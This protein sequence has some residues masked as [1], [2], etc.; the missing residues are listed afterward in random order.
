MARHVALVAG[1]LALLLARPLA[2]QPARID[3]R[4]PRD[5]PAKNASGAIRG[6]VTGADNGQPLRKAQVRL[7][8][9]GEGRMPTRFENQVTTTDAQGR[10][11]FAELPAGRYQLQAM[12]GGYVSLEYG[13]RRPV[14]APKPIELFAAQT[15]EKIDFA[16]PRG[17]VIAGRVFDEFGEPSA[18]VSVAAMR[19]QYDGRGR[20]RLMSASGA[21]TNDLGEFR[22]FALPPGDY[23]LLVHVGEF[24]D[25]IDRGTYAPLYYPGTTDVNLAER[26]TVASGQTIANLTL[27]LQTARTARVSGTAT[28]AEGKPMPG[29]MVVNPLGAKVAGMNV[30]TTIVQPDGSFTVGGLTPG[31]YRFVA[32]GVP[33]L[34][35]SE[36]VT[37]SATVAV[38][39]SD[40]AGL[41]VVAGKPVMAAGKI[42]VSG[43]PRAS[44]QVRHSTLRLLAASDD[45]SMDFSFNGNND[46][47][48][49]NDDGSFQIAL[50]PGRMRLLVIG[51]P[52]EWSMK[53]VR[54]GGVD[55]TDTGIDVKPAED[56][57]SLEIEL[58]D[59]INQTIG[60]VVNERNEPVKDYLVVI[61]SKDRQ[62]WSPQ[63]R[64]VRSVRSDQ[65]GRFTVGGLPS[66]EY[67][68]YATDF[69]EPGQEHDVEFLDRIQPLATRFLL[70]D[71]ETHTVNL[72]LHPAP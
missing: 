10:F 52:P 4:S 15:I 11:E 72:T 36:S 13:Q 70:G 28:D 39:T 66:G 38:D 30:L 24:G 1:M 48:P 14:E 57:S 55:V 64:A 27:T 65:D 18:N 3:E 69:I 19:F 67:F 61:F 32:R 40:I 8:S 23:Y 12:K 5:T 71:G 59:R 41:R 16:L 22:M 6:R 26:L 2:Q 58:T 63:S 68:A 49:V 46:G 44:R 50:Q 35:S 34:G 51:T 17:A 45:D 21:A 9:I 33:M 47:T 54:L 20:R 56:L 25:S 37:A 43:D 31:E 53:A 7:T 60:L 29:F 62:K 42:V